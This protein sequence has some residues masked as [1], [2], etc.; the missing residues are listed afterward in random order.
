VNEAEAIRQW[1][2][3]ADF[4]SGALEQHDD[5]HDQQNRADPDP[6]IAE[7]PVTTAAPAAEGGAETAAEQN[8]D[9]N[10]QKNEAHEVS[11]GQCDVDTNTCAGWKGF[12]GVWKPRAFGVTQFDTIRPA[13]DRPASRSVCMMIRLTLALLVCLPAGTAGAQTIRGAGGRPCTDWVQARR[14]GGRDFEAEQWALGYLS[15]VAVTAGSRASVP[16]EKAVFTSIDRYCTAHE[17]E[18]LWLAVRALAT[19]HPDHGS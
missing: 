3:S 5:Q 19:Q 14:G 8:D 16:E 15:G 11:F 6:A 12:V 7:M 18:S 9:Q 13:T 4:A 1:V 2:A 17:G 10:N